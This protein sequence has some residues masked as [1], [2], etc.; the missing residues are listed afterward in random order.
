MQVTEAS[1]DGLR[2]N[3]KIVVGAQELTDRLSKRIDELK[4]QIQLKGFRRG[5]VPPGHIRKV[6]GRSIMAEMIQQTVEES[7]RKAISDRGERPAQTPEIDLTEDK[8]EIEK[9][10]DGKSDL[11]YLLKYEAL[12]K[13]DLGDF[14]ALKLERL[15]ADV[16]AD[17]VEKALGELQERNLRYE[18]E[19]GRTRS[20]SPRSLTTSP[21][22]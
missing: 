18:A 1:V 15:V 13:I 12:P 8:A 7:S 19:E 14:G 21:R 16:P 11:A 6:Y 5:K 10:I 9:V 2:R 17:A 20:R 22:A 4:D 3:L